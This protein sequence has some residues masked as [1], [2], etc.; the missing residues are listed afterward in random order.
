VSHFSVALFLKWTSKFE[1]PL[2]VV[3]I[4]DDASHFV[5]CPYLSF[6][7]IAAL[8]EYS[9]HYHSLIHSFISI[10]N[11]VNIMGLCMCT[12]IGF[13]IGSCVGCGM[14]VC[15]GSGDSR[16]SIDR[17]AVT[18][19]DDVGDNSYY[20]RVQMMNAKMTSLRQFA[21]V[22]AAGFLCYLILTVLC[23]RA[24]GN[25]WTLIRTDG[26]CWS[27]GGDAP[28]TELGL[29]T[30]GLL[31][32][33]LFGTLIMTCQVAVMKK[34]HDR[35]R[36]HQTQEMHAIPPST[37]GKG[38]SDQGGAMPALGLAWDIRHNTASMQ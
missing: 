29:A 22:L 3:I 37:T 33:G 25:A 2:L 38:Y 15:C 30:G 35:A 34:Q 14:A 26:E 11:I 5:C 4:D 18:R 16:N 20:E 17:T 27:E 23:A 12:M 1:I 19:T 13:P 8:G 10:I 21:A 24:D 31:G 9:S 7:A 6:V 28:F 32:V 36:H